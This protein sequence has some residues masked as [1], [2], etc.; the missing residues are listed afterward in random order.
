MP[1]IHALTGYT[2]SPIF[3]PAIFLLSVILEHRTLKASALS[4]NRAK[5]MF[6]M[7]GGGVL[8]VTGDRL[9][10]WRGHSDGG[11]IQGTGYKQP[12]AAASEHRLREADR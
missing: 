12:V 11:D 6:G 4:S 8:V 3:L 1:A 2:D 10:G 9:P 5:K 7:W